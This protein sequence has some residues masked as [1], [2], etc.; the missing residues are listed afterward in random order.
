M[1][2]QEKQNKTNTKNKMILVGFYSETKDKQQI[3]E[4]I[5]ELCTQTMKIEVN[6]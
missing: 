3:N 6:I 2:S 5:M 4:K 1:A